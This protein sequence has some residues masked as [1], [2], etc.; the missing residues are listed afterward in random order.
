MEYIFF[1]F[2]ILL[3]YYD[4]FKAPNVYS[5][6]KLIIGNGLGILL[7]FVLFIISP[8]IVY[9]FCKITNNP[10]IDINYTEQISIKFLMAFLI[11]FFYNFFIFLFADNLVEGI[12]DFHKKY[13]ASNS[14]KKLI[15]FVFKNKDKIKEYYKILFFITSIFMFYAVWFKME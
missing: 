11:I 8:F 5:K 9:L 15:R 3:F 6:K 12:V 14:N 2:C 7:S 10:N 13:N 1:L 4:M